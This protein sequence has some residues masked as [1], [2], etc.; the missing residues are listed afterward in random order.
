MIIFTVKRTYD[1][2]ILRDFSSKGR[3]DRVSEFSVIPSAFPTEHFFPK[4][5]VFATGN[6]LTILE[7][8]LKCAEKVP[9]SVYRLSRV[10]RGN[11]PKRALILSISEKTN[12]LVYE[13]LAEWCQEGN[14][15]EKATI[16]E[17]F[18]IYFLPSLPKPISLCYD[19]RGTEG[20]QEVIEKIVE[21]IGEFDLVLIFSTGGIKIRYI[22][23]ASENASKDIEKLAK[24]Y[25]NHHGEMGNETGIEMCT[26]PKHAFSPEVL[27]E[28]KWKE[29]ENLHLSSSL[30]IQ[31][32]CCYEDGFGGKGYQENREA[33]QAVLRE[34]S[35]SLQL[36]SV[37][38][39]ELNFRL[40]FLIFAIILLFIALCFCRFSLSSD[41]RDFRYTKNRFLL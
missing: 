22:S 26:N 13:M 39:L 6:G 40:P 36:T 30:L 35:K 31:I 23:A 21:E 5:I 37:G 27:K 7:D 29:N 1:L 17:N 16:L 38:V 33:I 12:T 24:I 14:S 34:M 25:M 8:K 28:F 19:Y 2:P 32:S 4:D 10:K 41:R 18:S 20:F 3:I 9:H 15:R 11:A